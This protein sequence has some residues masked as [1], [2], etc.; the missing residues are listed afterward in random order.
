MEANDI[1]LIIIGFAGALAVF[2]YAMKL[3]SEGLQKVAG[4]RLRAAL[5]RFT[6]NPVKGIATGIGV[7]AAIQSS[8]ATTVMV[9][10]FVNAGL[11][12]LAG[13]VA[14]IM[15]ANI[16]TTV[17][18]WIITLLGLGGDDGL[19]SLPL[20]IA[21][22]SFYFLVSKK[23]RMRNIGQTVMGLA[24]LL[25]GM[26]LLQAAMP[27]LGQYPALLR[28]IASLSGYGFWSVLIFVGIGTLLTC[29][30]QASAAM[31][32]ITLVMCYNGWIGLDMAVALVMGQNIGTTIT[33]N[34]AATVA[35]T[36]GKQAAR[37]HLLFNVVGVLIT[38]VLFTPMLHLIAE[39]THAVSGASPHTS[40]AVIPLAISFFH[41]LFNVGNTL[42][43]A[44]FIP[45]II[46]LVNRMVVE[47]RPSR[48]ALLMQRVKECVYCVG[49]TCSRGLLW[50]Y[51]MNRM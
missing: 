11:L 2:L 43:L 24:L 28:G 25:V 8:S 1:L 46:W 5:A 26:E 36:A 13:A 3:M 29:L 38:L 50:V 45:Q 30:V 18:A 9:V 47:G 14:V 51:G 37:A 40:A 39:V 44:F 34:L 41:T 48:L 20:T 7:T 19:F 16:G 12:S 15:G 31:M 4:S 35:N 33:A 10:S 42:L 22:V 32:A 17:T 6:D 21:A 49:N 23:D 27:D